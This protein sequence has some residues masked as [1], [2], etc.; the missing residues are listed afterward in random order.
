MKNI[1]GLG[2]L[3]ALSVSLAGCLAAAAGAGV[4]G[5]RY[6][7]KHYHIEKKH[8]PEKKENKDAD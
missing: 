3:M 1:I 8:A 6:F 5:T 4:A 7:D 2:V